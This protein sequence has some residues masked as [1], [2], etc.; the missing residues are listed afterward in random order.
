MKNINYKKKCNERR[1]EIIKCS[2]ANGDEIPPWFFPMDRKDYKKIKEKLDWRIKLEEEKLTIIKTLNET[3]EIATE[4]QVKTLGRGSYLSSEEI[5]LILQAQSRAKAKLGEIYQPILLDTDPARYNMWEIIQNNIEK[6]K[7]FH[8]DL[9]F[10]DT[11]NAPHCAPIQ[12]NF[13]GAQVTF[14]VVEAA[15]P[16]EL[17]VQAFIRKQLIKRFDYTL[18]YNLH[19]GGVQSD[20]FNC[21]IFSINDLRN[22]S[23]LQKYEDLSKYTVAPLSLS[24]NDKESIAKAKKD[25][26]LN[27]HPIFLKY[28]QSIQHINT[29]LAIPQNKTIVIDNKNN[30]LE[31]HKKNLIIKCKVKSDDTHLTTEKERSFKIVDKTLKY[32]KAAAHE[33]ERIY[34]VG[35]NE[36]L[37]QIVDYRTATYF[38]EP[39]TLEN[40]QYDPA[41]QLF[42]TD[43]QGL[44]VDKIKELIS[45]DIKTAY[46]NG[47]TSTFMFKHSLDSPTGGKLLELYSQGNKEEAD[48]DQIIECTKSM[49]EVELSDGISSFYQAMDK[50]IEQ[51]ALVKA[52]G[53]EVTSE[54]KR[55]VREEIKIILKNNKKDL[56]IAQALDLLEVQDI[57][58]DILKRK[59]QVSPQSNIAQKKSLMQLPVAKVNTTGLNKGSRDMV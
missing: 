39:E 6:K 32:L 19:N 42:S 49:V 22:M 47:I 12:I 16:Y 34:E 43:F 59:I 21:A 54:N 1:A 31:Q 23:K 52:G 18:N 5:V 51:L 15:G 33:L 40:I 44:P 17:Q 45:K 3:G 58:K 56:N 28:G 38:F 8:Y 9:I 41:N 29:N 14:F 46:D 37:H 2:K 35:G 24:C 20:Y 57:G 50:F 25:G 26:I 10:K 30:T 48:K 27:T 53:K 4:E 36:L 13:D 11:P 55:Q 7:K